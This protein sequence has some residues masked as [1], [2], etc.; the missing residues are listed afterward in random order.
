MYV[1]KLLKQSKISIIYLRLENAAAVLKSTFKSNKHDT[2][3]LTDCGY[4]KVLIWLI[5][6]NLLYICSLMAGTNVE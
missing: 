5:Q 4:V 2:Q 6:T 3:G 1:R